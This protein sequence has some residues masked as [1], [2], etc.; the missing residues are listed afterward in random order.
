MGIPNGLFSQFKAEYEAKISKLEK[1]IDS[2][3]Q[4]KKTIDALNEENN[5][6]KVQLK[7]SKDEFNKLKELGQATYNE[8]D[9]YK[10]FEN[11][12]NEAYFR[13]EPYKRLDKADSI[14][15]RNGGLI[16]EFI[17]LTDS[18][19]DTRYVLAK[20]V[21]DFNRNR[22]SLDSLTS[23]VLEKRYDRA[24]VQNAILSLNQ[25]PLLDKGSALGTYRVKL[26]K[27]LVNYD[28]IN[29]VASNK[30]QVLSKKMIDLKKMGYTKQAIDQ[31]M[32]NYFEGIDKEYAY[33]YLVYNAVKSD[34]ENI[35]NEKYSLPNTCSVQPEPKIEV[36]VIEEKVERNN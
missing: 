22:V 5:Q 30:F 27:L 12:Y 8:Y 23:Y 29:C 9:W 3:S 18:P 17:L 31:A 28:S 36:E 19:K 33:L 13:S 1:T 25:L 21:M 35:N 26:E 14:K 6:L 11:K 2:L 34:P 24:Q 20:R 4:L 7:R 15:I 10:A 32:G 16:A